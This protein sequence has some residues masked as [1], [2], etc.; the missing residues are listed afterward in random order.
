MKHAGCNLQHF[1]FITL[2]EAFFF[3]DLKML[4]KLELGL[5]KKVF[6]KTLQL[7]GKPHNMFVSL[8]Q[9]LTISLLKPYKFVAQNFTLI[10]LW[11]QK[12]MFKK[13]KKKEAFCL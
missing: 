1:N 12:A 10:N 5:V 2:K 7:L 8:I 13:F 9:N 4:S 6:I 3:G 11:R